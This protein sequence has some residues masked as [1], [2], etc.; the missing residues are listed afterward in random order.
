MC[1]CYIEITELEVNFFVHGGIF[2][3]MV[4]YMFLNG[5]TDLLMMDSISSL[6]AFVIFSFFLV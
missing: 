4:S 1:Y 6:K 5:I 2:D 3:V